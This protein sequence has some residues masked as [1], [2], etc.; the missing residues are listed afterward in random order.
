MSL[1]SLGLGMTFTARDL[2]TGTMNRVRGSFHQ[3]KNE[4][5]GLSRQNRVTM[6]DMGQQTRRGSEGAA[7]GLAVFQRAAIG[8]GVVMGAGGFLRHAMEFEDGMASLRAVT[9]ASAGQMKQF[10]DAALQA[11]MATQFSP[12]QAVGAL[13][14]LAQAGFTATQ[15]V[16][17]LN[18]TL[19]LAAASLNKLSP[20]QAAGVASQAL[21]AFGVETK[22]AARAVDTMTAGINLF[23]MNADDLPLA[24][25]NASRGAGALNQGLSE[26]MIAFGLVKN[27]IPR[28]E[29][30]A[31]AVSVAME[32]M[33]D[34][35]VQG[36]LRG[37][38][39]SVADASGKFRPFL[40]VVGDMLPALGGMKEA[41]RAQFLQSTFG[42]EAMGGFNAILQQVTKGVTLSS[43]QVV[44]GAAAFAKLRAEMNA[45]G[46]A[47]AF[48]ETMLDSFPGQLRL[49]KGSLETLAVSV[50]RPLLR[51]FLP[52][53][54]LATDTVNAIV[55]AFNKLSGPVRDSLARAGMAFAVF[56]T[57]V[58]MGV[59][60]IS[61]P[62]AALSLTFASLRVAAEKNIGGVGRLFGQA[63]STIGTTAR[64]LFQLFSEGGFTGDLRAKFLEG[65]NAGVNMAVRIWLAF[66]RLKAFGAGVWAGFEAGL[67]RLSPVFEGFTAVVDRL[68]AAFGGG[69]TNDVKAARQAFDEM[70]AS[71]QRVGGSLA[72]V[73]A[74]L[75]NVLVMG[76]A[77]VEG[78]KSKWDEL[79]GSFAP[80]TAGLKGVS[81]AMSEAFTNAGLLQGGGNGISS[82]F[83]VVG[84]VL[85]GAALVAINGIA[86]G[87]RIASRYILAFGEIF[88][89]V[90][91]VVAGLVTGNWS[92][93]WTGVKRIVF[94]VVQSVINSVLT[95][96]E[97][98]GGA[99]DAFNKIAPKGAKMNFGSADI[100]A[101]RNKQEAWL[102]SEIVGE[103][104]KATKSG[105][106]SDPLAGLRASLGALEG[107]G[108]VP[109]S[110][111][112][113]IAAANQA[114]TQAALVSLAQITA[115]ARGSAGAAGPATTINLVVDGQVLATV[116]RNAWDDGAAREGAPL[117]A[118]G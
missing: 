31:T 71:G 115:K 83:R 78:F 20:S 87:L 47:D 101:W 38:G 11:G 41:Q 95:M 44:K 29:T 15:A 30:A 60:L 77:L 103:E 73:G 27:V 43:G 61:W 81:N 55:G 57:A 28:V 118:A 72:G 34:P 51:A 97:F 9:G 35:K 56:A 112:A 32:R 24:L 85:G 12:T 40:D 2:A 86:T 18:P 69:K 98:V 110:E 66:N 54:R 76:L 52:V 42:A 116:V 111:A 58:K 50:G 104:T 100:S 8:V 48:R 80:V 3:T 63:G 113:A 62:V 108:A 67:Q 84:A 114:A 10:E 46:T 96:V 68:G 37:L 92:R 16:E 65:G 75:V 102:R 64:A 14:D 88:G 33:V 79:G 82:V 45:T 17:L 4:M 7:A 74:V 23:S 5:Q 99:I 106:A 70:G 94:G 36:A 49:L 26:T 53:V 109:R 90:V 25:G 13:G 6:Q 22:D 39:V 89:G 93:A 105:K 21:K 117:P 59:N 91:D 107:G 1:N 19:N